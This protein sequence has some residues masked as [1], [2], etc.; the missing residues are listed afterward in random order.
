MLDHRQIAIVKSFYV[1]SK[2]GV[3][4]TVQVKP[5]S[6]RAGLA[7]VTDGR[8][9]VRVCARAVEGQANQA[10]CD[11]LCQLLN[12]PKSCV[13]ITRGVRSRDKTVFVQGDAQALL[14]KLNSTLSA[15]RDT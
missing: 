12:V 1:V 6:S 14:S 2:E 8:L 4:L 13:T 9:R 15:D 11:L 3:S 7:G 5:G 10:L